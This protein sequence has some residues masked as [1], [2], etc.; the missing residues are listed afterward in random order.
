MIKWIV[1]LIKSRHRE[2]RVRPLS[3]RTTRQVP[4]A[5]LAEVGG[6]RLPRQRQ[7]GAHHGGSARSSSR[8]SRGGLTLL[9]KEPPAL[10]HCLLPQGPDLVTKMVGPPGGTPAEPRPV[11]PLTAPQTPVPGSTAQASPGHEDEAS[12]AAPAGVPRDRLPDGMATP[13]ALFGKGHLLKLCVPV[14]PE[15]SLTT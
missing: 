15:G 13:R 4:A 9:G 10:G 2:G 5:G 11:W 6:D 3:S 1:A 7:E 8:G 12:N 14:P